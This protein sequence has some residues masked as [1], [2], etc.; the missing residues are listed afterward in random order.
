MQSLCKYTIIGQKLKEVL[1]VK[2]TNGQTDGG[3]DERVD[4]KLYYNASFDKHNDDALTFFI[5]R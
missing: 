1:R 4:G 2:P 3:T 5:V